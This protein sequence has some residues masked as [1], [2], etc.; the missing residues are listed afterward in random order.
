MRAN[1]AIVKEAVRGSP[2]SGGY[3]GAKRMI[4]LLAGYANAVAAERD[5]GIKLQVLVSL[6]MIGT[7]RD[8]SRGA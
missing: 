6:Q 4:S 5:L 2:L 8:R 7:T 3:A 1:F